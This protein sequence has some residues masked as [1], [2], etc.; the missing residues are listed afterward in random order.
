M[1]ASAAAILLAAISGAAVAALPGTAG[2]A[3]TIA[4]LL[5]GAAIGARFGR[6]RMGFSP[7]SLAVA[8]FAVPVLM[9]PV[10]P[11]SDMA[12]HVALARGLLEGELSAA[13]PTVHSGAYPRGFAALVALLSPLVLAGPAG[14][15]FR[16]GTDGERIDLDAVVFSRQLSGR[17]GGGDGLLATF[18]PF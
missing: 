3:V 13:W 15:G 9:M 17:E 18:T 2:P 5:L 8:A 12:M 10:A 1:T 6:S 7:W 4:G 14:G 16:S 11:G